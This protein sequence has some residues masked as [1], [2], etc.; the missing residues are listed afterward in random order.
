MARYVYRIVVDGEADDGLLVRHE[1]IPVEAEVPY[2]GRTI[3]V[4]EIQSLE[5]TDRTGQDLGEQLEADP[6]TQIARTLLCREAEPA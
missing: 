5:E 4:G 1:P 6:D 2:R 3:I